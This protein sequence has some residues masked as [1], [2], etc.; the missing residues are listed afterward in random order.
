RI[1]AGV[2]AGLGLLGFP[3]GT[4]ISAFILYLLFSK[5][6]AMVFSDEYKQV[7]ADTPDIKYRTSIIVWIFL[8]L[9]IAAAAFVLVALT[10]RH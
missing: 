8:A 3:F 5:K 10:L 1:V 2:L 4:V 6:G 9:L 7:I